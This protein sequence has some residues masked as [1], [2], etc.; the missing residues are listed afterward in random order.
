MS[1]VAQV[2]SSES[3]YTLY[4]IHS[5]CDEKQEYNRIVFKQEKNITK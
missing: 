2:D 4:T 5:Y 1:D 3:C